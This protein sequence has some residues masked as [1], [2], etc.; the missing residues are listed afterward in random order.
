MYPFFL[1]V[2]SLFLL[3]V[4]WSTSSCS[5]VEPYSPQEILINEL[6][7]FSP[8]MIAQRVLLIGD[9]GMWDKGRTN[10]TV[11]L[12]FQIA[13]QLPRK[14]LL[15]FLGDNVYEKGLPKESSIA[16]KEKEAILRT[17]LDWFKSDSGRLSTGIM[18]PGNHDWHGGKREGLQVIKRER[19]FVITHYGPN[20][21][22][23]P[24]RA[25]CPG[26]DV[27][28][29]G[30]LRIIALDTQWWL[31]SYQVGTASCDSLNSH[32]TRK[33]VQKAAFAR[34]RSLLANSE[35]R[36]TII[37]AHHP[38][39]SH[40]P[41]G[42]FFTLKDH[43]FPLTN[44]VKWA[45][46]PLPGIGSIYPLFRKY[47]FNNSQDLNSGKY[48]ALIDSLNSI[49]AN[50]P[51]KP[52]IYAAGHEHNLQILKGRNVH[53]I[54]ISGS[55]AKLSPVGDGDD[56]LFAHEEHGFIQLDFLRDGRIYLSVVEKD[57]DGQQGKI[58]Y[59]RQ[60]PEGN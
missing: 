55:G 5:H 20:V 2:V 40:G 46:I 10:T 28:D 35:N 17:Q 32:H 56:T 41:H 44:F 14:T 27:Y 42:G 22:F 59:S 23:L 18:I 34:L 47:V 57:P 15:I 8:N 38:L 31:H 51:H 54:V 13:S 58:I 60:I 1:R 43:I 45:Y 30:V 19:D 25:G 3:V 24:D 53:Y 26:P 48:Q 50:V 7:K 52:L 29:S 39:A 21:K 16:R 6:P 37:I 11:E 49:F 33:D 4:F 36:E 12:M 9:A